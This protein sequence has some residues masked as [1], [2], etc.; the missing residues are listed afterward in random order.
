[1]GIV[2]DDDYKFNY[3]S[4][5]KHYESVRNRPAVFTGDINGFQAACTIIGQK[6]DDEVALYTFLRQRELMNI[7]EMDRRGLPFPIYGH[8]GYIKNMSGL[9]GAIEISFKRDSTEETVIF[10]VEG[11]TKC[12]SREDKIFDM[13]SV[14]DLILPEP[15][16]RNSYWLIDSKLDQIFIECEKIVLADPPGYFADVT[17]QSY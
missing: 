6:F 9:E 13:Y 17:D 10:R 3:E 16:K 11:I 14:F 4:C 8:I 7:I 12:E 1:M 2:P 5:K 15:P